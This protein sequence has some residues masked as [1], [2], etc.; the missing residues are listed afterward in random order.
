MKQIQQQ[1]RQ[2]IELLK[3]KDQSFKIFGAKEHQYLLNPCLTETEIQNFEQ[4]YH[5]TLPDDYRDFLCYVGNGGAGPMYGLFSLEESIDEIQRHLIEVPQEYYDRLLE[6]CQKDTLWEWMNASRQIQDF[7]DNKLQSGEI[8]YDFWVQSFPL[9]NDNALAAIQE[10]INNP[11]GYFFID[12]D[13]PLGGSLP[14]CHQGCGWMY[15]LVINGEQ[16]GQ[17]WI[18][19]EQG[20]LPEF[21]DETSIQKKF[22]A[23]Y[24]SWLDSALFSLENTQN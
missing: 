17:I 10:R 13:Y 9:N 19:G 16:R 11:T 15:V 4:Q 6:S 22:L 1:I 14:I 12:K 7:F 5:V 24:Q 2:K 20:W 8:N 23:W 21:S 3:Q 18:A